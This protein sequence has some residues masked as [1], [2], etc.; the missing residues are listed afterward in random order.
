MK[1][2]AIHGTGYGGSGDAFPAYLIEAE[3]PEELP[4]AVL[5]ID[6][7]D[8][9]D[10]EVAQGYM[11]NFPKASA[12][13]IAYLSGPQHPGVLA[14]ED[15]GMVVSNDDGE[16]ESDDEYHWTELNIPK[17]SEDPLEDAMQLQE[18]WENTREG[19]RER[20]SQQASPQQ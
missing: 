13:D 1:F 2:L 14:R 16:L 15:D 7:G 3:G 6:G 9:R 5:P 19:Q 11:D 20:E 4:T 17:D 12:A 10:V 18:E 8:P